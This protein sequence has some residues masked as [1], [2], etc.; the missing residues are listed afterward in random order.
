MKNA[1]IFLLCFFCGTLLLFGYRKFTHYQATTVL[2]T[3]LP[4]TTLF[5]LAI[6]PKSSLKG[7]IVSYNGVV[8][9]QSREAT[10]EADLTS[11]RPV[12]QGE[13][14]RTEDSGHLQILFSSMEEITL[15]PNAHIEFVQT[16]PN[17][18]V[19]QQTGGEITYKK[20]SQTTPVAIRVLR[21]LIA[22]K[23]GEVMITIDEDQIITIEVIRGEVTLAFNDT[24][25]ISNVVTIIQGNSYIFDNEA[26]EGEVTITD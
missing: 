23:S 16:L 19:M 25:T 4:T 15:S 18:F 13:A 24:E 20:L 22:Q 1:F 11:K 5:S 8:A 9:W 7:H 3:P 17:S 2:K 14:Y 26:L 12:L 21:L 10:E 6:P